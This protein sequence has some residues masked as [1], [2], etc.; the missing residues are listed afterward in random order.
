MSVQRILDECIVLRVARLHRVLSQRQDMALRQLGITG[1]QL[2]LLAYLHEKGATRAIDLCNELRIE[3][4]TMSR[5]LK[6]LLA[7]EFISEGTFR[8]R[9][10]KLVVITDP[11]R[12]MVVAAF[13]IWEAT[14]KYLLEHAKPEER[15][16]LALLG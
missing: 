16:A 3:K 10:G 14:Q 13:P 6:R 9:Y 12:G 4:S 15:E 11:G 5:N 8:R 1:P 7:A 2:V